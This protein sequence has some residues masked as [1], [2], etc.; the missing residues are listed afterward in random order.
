MS[1]PRFFIVFNPVAGQHDG[2]QVRRAFAATFGQAGLRY[3]VYE[4][5][6]GELLVPV[7][8][9]ALAE[10]F[11]TVVAAG[12]DGT[13]AAVATALVGGTIPLGI[14][15]VGTTN[16]VAR[17]LGLPLQPEAA[18]QVLLQSRRTVSL[19]VM[20][21]GTRAFLSHISMGSY[22]R[23]VAQ[24]TRQAK[25]RFGRLVHVWYACKELA[26]PKT[27]PFTVTVDTQTHQVQATTILVAN[28]G[29]AGVAGV[30]WGAHI[31][32][33]DGVLNV[34]ILRANGPIDSLRALWHLVRHPA[35]PSP[36]RLSLQATRH[37]T[38]TTVHSVP[39]R[40]DGEIIGDSAVDIRLLPHAVAVI[41]PV[42]HGAPAP[43][44]VT[45]LPS[46]AST[47]RCS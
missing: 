3:T 13:V 16:I 34:V 30:R 4:T 43:S 21:V 19:D 17:E 12:G 15:P 27:W 8:Q 26:R 41:V 31:A 10:Q 35:Q 11:T 36:T 38:I 37:V 23:I 28:A 24:A 42:E 32:P 1:P 22:A 2:E 39:V 46:T 7:V 40:A 47:P 20:Q 33:H 14:V 29:T 44:L 6:A 5:Q 18:C 9:R 25:R 45:C